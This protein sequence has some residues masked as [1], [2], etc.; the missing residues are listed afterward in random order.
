MGKWK[1]K[2]TGCI[3]MFSLDVSFARPVAESK[4]VDEPMDDRMHIS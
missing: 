2:K 4:A 3:R 1:R